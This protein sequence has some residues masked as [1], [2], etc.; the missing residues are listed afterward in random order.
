MST[1][2]WPQWRGVNRDGKSS[3]TGL[4]KKRPDG[5]PKKLRTVDSIGD[6]FSTASRA[7][8]MVYTTGMVNKRGVIFG[9]NGNKVFRKGYIYG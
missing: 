8:K 5:G 3:E 9:I 7:D 2:Y 4:L 1:G 6:A